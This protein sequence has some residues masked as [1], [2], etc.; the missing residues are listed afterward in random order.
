MFT[1]VTG[2]P[3]IAASASRAPLL[4]LLAVPLCLGATLMVGL[5]A[6]PQLGPRIENRLFPILVDQSI[7]SRSVTRTGRWLCWYW[8]RDKLRAPTIL[9]LDVKLDTGDGDRSRPE[10]INAATGVPWHTGGALP[11][12]HYETPFCLV[13][14]E[15]AS[16]TQAVRVR[17]TITYQGFWG[18][19]TLDVPLP[20]IVAN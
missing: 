3:P 9:G 2:L 8:V 18:L 17:Q 11:P 16:E 7:P 14:P 15:Y 20:E 4:G 10:V 13:L 6:V 1:D 5:V 19:W 12:G